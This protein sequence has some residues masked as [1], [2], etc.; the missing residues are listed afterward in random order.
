MLTGFPAE[1]GSSSGSAV[2]PYTFTNR[3]VMLYALGGWSTE[4]VLSC[5][6]MSLHSCTLYSAIC[7]IVNTRQTQF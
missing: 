4:F 7:I 3:D 5:S 2:V 1:G 6:Y